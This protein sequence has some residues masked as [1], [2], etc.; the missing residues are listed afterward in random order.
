MRPMIRRGFSMVELMIALAITAMLL[1]STLVALDAGFKGYKH[2]ADGASVHVV[3]RIVMHRV[4]SM[5][6]NGVNFGPYPVDPLDRSTNPLSSTFIEF[7][8][9]RDDASGRVVIVRVERRD[10]PEGGEGPFELW[11]LQTE[12]IDGVQTGTSAH[13]LLAGV[14]EASFTLEYDVGPRLKRATVDI[15]ILPSGVREASISTDLNAPVLRLV[16]SVVPRRL[17]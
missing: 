7:E 1:A 15:S 6:R 17:D 12:F 11:Y 13:P 2:T 3:S 9:L 10:A 16:S 4:T 8:A 5:V 14:Q